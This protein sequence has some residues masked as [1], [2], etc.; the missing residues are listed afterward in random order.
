MCSGQD[1][2]MNGQAHEG[3][4]ASAVLGK[5]EWG[6]EVYWEEQRVGVS[7]IGFEQ[8]MKMVRPMFIIIIGHKARCGAVGW[9]TA[10]QVG[11]SR[12]RFPMVSL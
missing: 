10:L 5:S 4:Y 9:G 7:D 11:R 3:W 8:K 12:V 2:V 1:A 6:G